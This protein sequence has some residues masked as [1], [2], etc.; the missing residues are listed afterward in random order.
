MF[1][2]ALFALM[3]CA[4]PLG[5]Q[6]RLAQADSAL[7]TGQPWR[8]SQLLAPILATPATRTPDAIM[9]AA[10]AAAGWEGWSTVR[11]LLESQPWLDTRYD[12]LGRRLLAEGA[13]AD[14]RNLDA[15]RHAAAAATPDSLRSAAEQGRR[16][17]ILA[18]S[19]ARLSQYDSAATVYRRAAGLLPALAD[20]LTL[21]AAAA[22][23]DSTARRVLYRSVAVPAAV[24][25]IAWTEAAARERTGDFAGAAVRYDSVGAWVPALHARWQSAPDSMRA[26]MAATLAARLPTASIADTRDALDLIGQLHPAFTATDRLLVARRAAAIGRNQDAVDQFA[27]AA[28]AAPLADRDRFANATALAALSHWPDAIAAFAA[29]RTGPLAGQAAYGRA[30]ALLRGGNDA[31]ASTALH[32]VITRFPHDTTAASIALLLLGDLALDNGNVDST[33]ADYLALATRYPTSSQRDHAL[34]IAAL[35]ALAHDKAAVAASDIRKAL[36]VRPVTGL[37]GDALHY[38]LARADLANA[39]TA[40]AR[41]GFQSLLARGPTNYYAIRAAARLDTV[42][43]RAIPEAPLRNPDSLDGVFTRAALLSTFGL[44]AEAKLERDRIANTATGADEL[45]GTAL[46]FAIRGYP[47]QAGALANRAIAAGETKDVLLWHLLYPLPYADALRADASREGVDPYLAASVIKQESGFDPH[48]TSRTNARGLMQVEPATGRELASLAGTADFD[49][50]M[51][52]IPDVN[53]ALGMHHFAG[54]L[55]RYP[56]AERALAAYNA[57]GTPVA[58]WSESPLDGNTRT[59]EHA[60]DPLDDPEMFVERIPFVETRGY[61]RTV[62]TN[63]AV[64]RMLYPQ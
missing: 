17:I 1:R 2:R 9:L 38:W 29:I 48:A 20:W 45:A 56:E 49:P 43:W 33:R 50:A 30:R 32:S 64:Y 36:A 26:Q 54:V 22:T 5:A 44:D 16:L 41:R 12:R 15:F 19:Y 53:L 39:D 7:A 24:A 34:L 60:R 40:A 37:D 27:A 55:S 63:L 31:A 23:D 58:Q 25:R 18:R 47:A 3:V 8:A 35:I 46:A 11:Q 28:V 62:L 59:A 57:G 13:L 42:P 14:G 21:R 51:L 52:W 10:R 6:D 4:A 61:V